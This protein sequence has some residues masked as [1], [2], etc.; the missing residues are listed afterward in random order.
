MTTDRE[1]REILFWTK[2]EDWFEFDPSAEFD[3]KLTDIAP[4]EAVESFKK[5]LAYQRAH[6]EG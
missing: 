3:Y 5:W 4:P 2:N 1:T 6:L